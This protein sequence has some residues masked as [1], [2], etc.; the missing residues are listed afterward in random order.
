MHQAVVSE[1]PSIAERLLKFLLSTRRGEVGGVCPV[2]RVF[3]S[4]CCVVGGVSRNQRP[5]PRTNRR[6]GPRR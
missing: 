4:V 5:H 1:H 6:H 2:S 3:L